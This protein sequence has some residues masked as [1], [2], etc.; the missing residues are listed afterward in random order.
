VYKNLFSRHTLVAG[1]L[2]CVG[3][4]WLKSFTLS[5]HAEDGW[6]VGDWLVHYQHGFVRRGLPGTIFVL[7]ARAS[8]VNPALLVWWFQVLVS[9]AFFLLFLGAIRNKYLPLWFWTLLLS[10]ATFL[11]S[12]Y[13]GSAVTGRKELLYF[14]VL[15]AFVVGLQRGAF[16][17]KWAL[18]CVGLAAFGSTLSH[19][20]FFFYTPYFVGAAVLDRHKRPGGFTAA[21]LVCASSLLAIVLLLFSSPINAN[22]MCTTLLGLGMSRDVCRGVIG[23]PESDLTHTFFATLRYASDQHYYWVYPAS[24]CLFVSP[25]VVYRLSGAAPSMNRSL[26]LVVCVALLS[27]VPLFVLAVDWGRWV[28]IHCMSVLMLSTLLLPADR[29]NRQRE[30]RPRVT[31]LAGVLT[32]LFYPL[33]WSMP[34]CCS[35]MIGRGAVPMMRDI[36]SRVSIR[37]LL[38][39]S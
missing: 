32:L 21:A 39:R 8:H 2:G 31:L 1:F 23:W 13:E 35:P 25:F 34:Y 22:P 14:L 36:R 20:L 29:D 30:R 24:V 19:E 16:A 5:F 17:R 4:A 38:R 11:F 15:A 10:P 26:V 7:A 3:W 28:N 27:S 33:A 6:L 37:S 9:T 12:V 18:L